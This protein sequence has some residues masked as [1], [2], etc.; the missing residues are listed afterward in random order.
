MTPRSGWRAGISGLALSDDGAWLYYGAASHGTLYRVPTALLQDP[1]LPHPQLAVDI[2]TVGRK[3]LSDG[4]AADGDVAYVSDVERGGILRYAP[5]RPVA[6]VL[7][8]DR[9]RWPDALTLGPD[10]ALYIADSALGAF[11]LKSAD[12][13]TANAPYRIWRVDPPP[14]PPGPEPE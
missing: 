12:E 13:A 11:L 10:G 14:P 8:D 9:I 4:I 3:P 6:T 2:E 5:E 7:R 1:R